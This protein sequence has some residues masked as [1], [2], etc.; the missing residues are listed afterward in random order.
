[1]EPAYLQ[2]ADSI[3]GKVVGIFAI[4]AVI[5]TLAPALH[6]P[7]TAT[8]QRALWAEAIICF[9]GAA[10]YCYHAYAPRG[11]RVGPDPK[12]LRCKEWLALK[13]SKYRYRM[14]GF[15]GE[16]YAFN[17]SVLDV[18]AAARHCWLRFAGLLLRCYS[19]LWP[20]SSRPPGE[21]LVAIL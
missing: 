21:L 4:A 20:F 15:M 8:I 19:W 2:W 6:H 9:L 3:D 14:L 11:F 18:K 13:P 1:M 12:T 10:W 17:Q 7:G 5:L 16:T